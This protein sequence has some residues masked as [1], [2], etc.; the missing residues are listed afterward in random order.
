MYDKI[1]ICIDARAVGKSDMES[2]CDR[3]YLQEVGDANYISNLCIKR[4]TNSI[5]ITGSFTK[6]MYGD[7]LHTIG[8][9]ETE[10]IVETLSEISGCDISNARV[11]QLEFGTNFYLQE[12]ISNYL[13]LLD[14][15]PTAIRVEGAKNDKRLET[16]YYYSKGKNTRFKH[17]FYD[18]GAEM[19][20]NGNILRYELNYTKR[21]AT[22]LKIVGGITLSTLHNINFYSYMLKRYCEFYCAIT[23]KRDMKIAPN[24]IK[25]VSDGYEAFVSMLIN[26]T[27]PNCIEEFIDKLKSDGV[28]KDP[29][30]YTRL[31]NKLKKASQCEMT[32]STKQL[33]EELDMRV[34]AVRPK[35]GEQDV[36]IQKLPPEI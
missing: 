31:K 3:F 36:K 22:E 8:I 16:L 1:K 32:T 20:I 19:G 5:S 15:S 24:S 34:E 6:F 4:H 29:K 12:P 33:I 2:I 25:K 11:V 21:I 13:K 26:N 30:Y 27:S 18:K 23:K 7:N 10:A 28:Y 17:R 14:A 9:A 35:S